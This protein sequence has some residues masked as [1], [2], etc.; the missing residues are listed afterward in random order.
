MTPSSRSRKKRSLPL[1]EFHNLCVY[2][3]AKKALSSL[4][5]T[6]S[7]GETVAILGPNGAGKSSFIKTVLRELYPDPD[8]KGLIFRI[9]GK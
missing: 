5:V 4:S 7:E 6:I 1:L 8:T 3:G 2:I 9:R